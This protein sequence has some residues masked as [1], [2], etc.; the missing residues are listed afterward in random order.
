MA[1]DVI[2]EIQLASVRLHGH[3]R[4]H[5]GLDLARARPIR[6]FV[7]AIER[8]PPRIKVGSLNMMVLHVEMMRRARCVDAAKRV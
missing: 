3:E 6:A 5:V 8:V 4:W 2:D 7:V 1:G